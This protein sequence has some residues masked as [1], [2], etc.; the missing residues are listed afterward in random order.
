MTRE[1]YDKLKAELDQM[2]TVDM[3]QILERI[4]AARSEGDLRENAE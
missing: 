3:P 2:E 4:A 1:G